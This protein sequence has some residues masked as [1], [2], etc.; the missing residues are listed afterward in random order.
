MKLTVLIL[1]SIS[2]FLPSAALA[3][4]KD[5]PKFVV[6]TASTIAGHQTLD[7][8]TIAAVP[9]ITDEQM[10]SAFGK[11]DPVKYGV[12]PVLV[13]LDNGTGKTIRL[14]LKA[15]LVTADER[16][17]DAISSDDVRRVGAGVK[18]RRT[19]GTANPLPF[20]LPGGSKGGPLGAWEIEGRAFVAKLLPPGETASGFF[21]FLAEHEPGQ[22]IYLTGIKDAATGKDFFY[23]E[24]PIQGQ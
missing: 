22:R 24:V 19:L 10:K 16:H 4:D 11:A 6:G 8:I 1:L 18:P 5:R 2:M 15:E 20:P 23:F 3:A 7:K 13:V 12:L 17:Q 14:D 21:Y 9:Y